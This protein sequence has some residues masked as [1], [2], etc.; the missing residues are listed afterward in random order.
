MAKNKKQSYDW[1]KTAKKFGKNL[2]YIFLA[3]IPIVFADDPVYLAIVPILAA[4]EN[5]IKHKWL[6]N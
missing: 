3:G 5:V 1:T 2:V 6:K 4:L